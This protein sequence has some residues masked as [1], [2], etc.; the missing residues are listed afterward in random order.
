MFQYSDK[1][2]DYILKFL[3]I[4]FQIETLINI[5]ELSIIF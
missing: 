5:R 1:K 4:D 2:E 3:T